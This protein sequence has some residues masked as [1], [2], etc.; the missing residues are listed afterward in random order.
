MIK[1][2]EEGDYRQADMIKGQV[3]PPP[4]KQTILYMPSL[5]YSRWELDLS[6]HIMRWL[7]VLVVRD[8]EEM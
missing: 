1:K 5:F 2:G 8:D 3:P 6:G 4:Y 7:P